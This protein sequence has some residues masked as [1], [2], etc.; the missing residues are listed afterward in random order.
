MFGR[1]F[2]KVWMGLYLSAANVLALKWAGL[3]SEDF[4]VIMLMIIAGCLGGN[5]M[6]N[7]VKPPGTK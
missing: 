1:G 2:R 4:K 6:E 5:I 7:R 3:Q